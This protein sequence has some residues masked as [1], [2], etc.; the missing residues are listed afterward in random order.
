[1]RPLTWVG[2][3][4]LV[5]VL[6]LSLD[7]FD[8]VADPIGW[9][10]VCL[11][12]LALP[13][14]L[15]RGL[16]VGAAA[17]AAIVSVVLLFPSVIDTL[18]GE[19]PLSWA[20]SLPQVVFVLLLARAMARSAGGAG[21]VSARGWWRLVLAGAIVLLLLPPVVYGAGVGT[22]LL[23]GALIGLVAVVAAVVL[24]LRHAD[25]P[26]AQDPGTPQGRPS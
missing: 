25:R 20:V 1:M 26:W 13:A 22:V 12:C 24:S 2:L 16:L 8:V 19:L 3:G 15:D 23:L 21:D 10:L 5:V 9:S 6:D 17:V 11:G 14:H 7:G 4:L 18:E